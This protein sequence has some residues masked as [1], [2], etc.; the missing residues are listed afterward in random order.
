[1]GQNALLSTHNYY[2]AG[3]NTNLGFSYPGA[4]YY[5]KRI[6]NNG[7]N[8]ILSEVE[9][10][11]VFL[12]SQNNL[13]KID[14][15]YAGPT[16]IYG[17]DGNDIFSISSTGTGLTPGSAFQVDNILGALNLYGGAGNNTVV[18]RDSGE[19]Q[20]NSGTYD[21]DT[22]TGLDMLGSITINTPLA[23][24][25]AV[26]VLLGVQDDTFT[27]SNLNPDHN[28]DITGNGGTNT[29]TGCTAPNC[30]FTP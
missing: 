18:V 14:S 16:N 30:T 8:T 15:A 17:N 6:R 12:G 11:E 1:M 28:V 13:V 2:G 19:D 4:I 22:I 7:E 26:S 5:A 29:I 3:Y 23:I 9:V 25:I 27:F 21:N 20:P 10:V 24:P